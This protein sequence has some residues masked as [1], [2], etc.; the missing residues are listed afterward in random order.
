[1]WTAFSLLV[2]ASGAIAQP[3]Q[4][5][6]EPAPPAPPVPSA[7]PAPTAPTEGQAAPT[8]TEP[9]GVPA[10]AEPPANAQ[11]EPAPA[12]PP[13]PPPSA[14]PDDGMEKATGVPES[15]GTPAPLPETSAPASATQPLQPQTPAPPS[16]SFQFGSYGRVVVGGDL[17]GRPGRDTD[18]VARGSRL[19]ENTYL[20]LEFRR[21]DYWEKTDSNTQVVATLAFQHPIFHYNGN[22]DGV[23]GMRNL[24]LESRD[25][26]AKGLAFWAGS[27]MYR[28]DDIYLLD[29]W[30]L[31]NL[32]TLGA[33]AWYKFNDNRTVVAVHGGLT[34]PQDG[35][36]GQTVERPLPFNQ[37][38]STQVDIL[39]RQKFIGSLK[40][41]HRIKLGE[42]A[43]AKGILYGETHQL[44]SGQRETEPGRFERMASDSGYVIGGQLGA[45][46]GERDTFVNLF[47]RYARGLAAYPDFAAPGQLA[48]ARS[49]EG[50][51]EYKTDGAHEFRVAL[52]ANYEKGPIGVMFGAYFRSFR[53]ANP[54]LDLNDV[55]EGILIARPH[56]F[57]G[58]KGGIA[59]EA[60]Y[61][62]QQRGVLA[63]SPDGGGSLAG[64]SSGLHTAG[65]T[66]FGII[67]FLSP[68]GRGDYVRPQIRAMYVITLR[69]AGARALYPQDDVFSLRK[70]EHFFGIGAEWW[71]NNTWSYGG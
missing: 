53:N 46:T 27:R 69:D 62:A 52:G 48:I 44:P 3:A 57:I 40:L 20:E 66:R 33:G 54:D 21:E 47:V 25:L 30:P 1:M 56:Y 28:G 71:F 59:V 70:V 15:P 13:A 36:F 16:G 65:L 67:P 32:N 49:D 22:F 2:S 39:S 55:D 29:W 68:A 24:Y 38:G 17:T 31:D 34:R 4:P 63:A 64:G 41:N 61:Q 18:I 12:A 8:P 35:F 37:V 50:I 9:P 58:E 11:P 42:K 14:K 23:V 43:G 60:S 5:S 51:T 19:D 7:Q 26:L 10:P 6:P 45:W